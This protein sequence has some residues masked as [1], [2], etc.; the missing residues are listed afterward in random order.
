MLKETFGNT[1]D[2]IGD[3]AEGKKQIRVLSRVNT[4]KDRGTRMKHS[5]MIVK[6]LGLQGANTLSAPVSDVHHETAEL[7][8]REKFKKYQSLCARAK[9]LDIDRIDLQFGGKACRSVSGPTVR[10]RSKMKR[11]GRFWAGCPR[12]LYKYK[13]QD[14]QEM[15]TAHRD[16]NWAST[17]PD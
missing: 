2:I 1:T 5:E 11:T 15:L 14:E 10:D 6:E 4:V 8:D 12:P 13:F 3:G 9:F 17:A 16:A 7:L